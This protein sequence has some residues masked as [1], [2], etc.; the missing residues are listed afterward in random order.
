MV[1]LKNFFFLLPLLLFSGCMFSSGIYVDDGVIRD[2]SGNAL[3]STNPLFVNLTDDPLVTK[4]FVLA[5]S[6]GAYPDYITIRQYGINDDIDA[7]IV[8]DVWSGGGTLTYQTTADQVKVRSSDAADSGFILIKGLNGSYDLTEELLFM[9]GTTNFRTVNEYI[10]LYS[11][12]K[13]TGAE[14]VGEI[15][16]RHD[17]TNDIMTTIEPTIGTSQ[18]SHFIVPNCYNAQINNFVTSLMRKKGS[19]GTKIAEI[20]GLLQ[21]STYGGWYTVYNVGLGTA[22]TSAFY[23]DLEAPTEFDA[24]TKFKATGDSENNNNRVFVSYEI[25]LSYNEDQC[26]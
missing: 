10:F 9:N 19:S 4:D 12:S 14:N 2:E 7:N 13:V 6:K 26:S 15:T 3:N 18:M 17:T 22:G 11:A 20:E 5:A 21:P 8:E 16:L 1:K 25:L 24:L 23:S